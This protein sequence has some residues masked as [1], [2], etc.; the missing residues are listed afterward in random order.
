[1]KKNGAN[2]IHLATGLVVGY[3]PCPRVTDFRNFIQAKYGLDVVIGTHPI[4]QNYYVIHK[5]L[6]TWNSSRWTKI[7]QPTTLRDGL[8]SFNQLLRMKR[9]VCCMIDV[10]GVEWHNAVFVKDNFL[11]FFTV[12]FVES[13]NYFVKKL[14]FTSS[15]GEANG[16]KD[17]MGS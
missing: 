9:P 11:Y 14:S 3:P 7:I 6:G 1:M 8:R 16:Q 10:K 4:P 5:K 13:Q 17:Q 12:P 2:V 15:Y